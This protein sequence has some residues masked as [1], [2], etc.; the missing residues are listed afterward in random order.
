VKLL[1]FLAITGVFV[2]D[3]ASIFFAKIRSS[4]VASVAATACAVAYKR[5]NGDV[6]YAIAAALNA[7]R[8]KSAEVQ[9]TAV[10]PDPRTGQCSVTATASASTLVVEKIGFLKKFATAESTEVAERPI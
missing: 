7:A 8:D 3:G 10:I 1:L 6:D 9:L 5:N 4:D 2:A